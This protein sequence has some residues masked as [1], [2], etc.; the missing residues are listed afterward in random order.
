MFARIHGDATKEEVVPIKE[1]HVPPKQLELTDLGQYFGLRYFHARLVICGILLST[2]PGVINGACPYLLSTIRDEF[3]VGDAAASLVSTSILLGS[4]VGVLV[5]TRWSD[6]MGRKRVLMILAFIAILGCLLHLLIPHTDYGF[7][8]LVTLRILIGIPYG[9]L[10]IIVIPYVLEFCADNIRGSVGTALNLGFSIASIWSICSVEVLDKDNWR[11]CMALIPVIPASLALGFLAC[12]PESPRWLFTMGRQ[13][14]GQVIIDGIFES[15]PITG[16]AY[17]G[18]APTVIGDNLAGSQE[19]SSM[20]AYRELFS[21][22]LRSTT[23]VTSVL[24]FCIAC[25]CNSLWAWGPT[26]MNRVAGQTVG[27]WVFQVQQIFSVIGT[28][29]AMW[30]LDRA[31]RR[32]VLGVGFGWSILITV[33]MALVSLLESCHQPIVCA[34]WLSLEL[35]HGALFASLCAYMAEAFPTV[36]RGTGSGFAAV[37]GRI[38]SVVI[39][40]VLGPLFNHKIFAG[41]CIVAGLFSVGALF[42]VKIPREMAGQ[43]MDDDYKQNKELES[44]ESGLKKK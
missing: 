10:I 24:Y 12:M 34:L 6:L 2:T 25:S 41:L 26:I 33:C 14:E 29:I 27:L 20:D 7:F 23:I 3:G 18:K 32:F 38:G 4:F 5:T 36:L 30:L 39:P 42:S 28:F 44:P 19:E 13:E 8:L 31:G 40:S 1:S 17:V 22:A 21:P 15:I 35:A 9:G 43:A 11:L 16:K 37:G